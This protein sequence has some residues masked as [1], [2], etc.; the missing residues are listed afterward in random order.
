[1]MILPGMGARC[2]LVR[3]RFAVFPQ[4]DTATAAEKIR[5]TVM[6]VSQGGVIILTITA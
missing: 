2:M 4:A 6:P 3:P 5:L 1:M